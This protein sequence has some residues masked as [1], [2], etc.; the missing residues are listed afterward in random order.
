VFDLFG[1]VHSSV[2]FQT[3][4]TNLYLFTYTLIFVVFTSICSMFTVWCV[5]V[6]VSVRERLRTC[7]LVCLQWSVHPAF[8]YLGLSVSLAQ[9]GLGFYRHICRR[10]REE[11]VGVR[12]KGIMNKWIR[13]VGNETKIDKDKMNTWTWIK[14]VNFVLLASCSSSLSTG[15]QN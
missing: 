2:I 5:C 9:E 6:S 13:I 1:L 4:K 11:R 12:Q 14:P 10:K 7:V 15:G 8:K 3:N